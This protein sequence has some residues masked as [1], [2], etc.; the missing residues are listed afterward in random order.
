[1]KR[2]LHIALVGA[3]VCG[4]MPVS[5]GAFAAETQKPAAEIPVVVDGDSVQ[6]DPSSNAITAAGD[7]KISYKDVTASCDKASVNTVTKIGTLTGNTKIAFDGQE[8]T[9]SNIIF[10]FETKEAEMMGMDFEDDPFYMKAESFEA[11]GNE[12]FKLNNACISTCG[13]IGGKQHFLDYVIKAKHIEY[14]PHRKIVARNAWMTINDIP[15]MYS[16]YYAQPT[17]DRLPRV[18]LTPGHD[19]EKGMFLLAAWRYYGDEGFRGR[20]NTDYYQNKGTGL[21]VTHKYATDRVGDGLLKGY[22]IQDREKVSFEEK[23]PVKEDRYKVQLNHAYANEY[24]TSAQVQVNKFSDQYFMKDYFYREYERDVQPMSYGLM[25]QGFENSTIGVM[26]QKRVNDFYSQTEY[27]PKVTMD[28]YKTQLADSNFYLESQNQIASMNYKYAKPSSADYDVTRVDTQ[29]ILS[30]QQKIGA[31][32]VS[33]F[34]G[35]RGTYYSR[36]IANEK[37]IDRNAFIGGTDVSTKF[38]RLFDDPYQLFGNQI[39]KTLHVVTPTVRYQYTHAPTVATSQLYQFDSYDALARNETVSLILE[40][41]LSVKAKL[42]QKDPL[43]SKSG[44]RHNN[45]DKDEEAKQ[46][47]MKDP[48]GYTKWDALYLAPDVNWAL[49]EEGRGSHPTTAGYRME[50]RPVSNIGFYQRFSQDIDQVER[51]TDVTTDMNVTTKYFDFTV[52]HRY[53][54]M[55]ESQFQGETSWRFAKTW[56]FD[57]YY[58]YDD[59]LAKFEQQGIYLNKELNCWNSMLAFEMDQD[60]AQKFYIMFTLKAFPEAA[61]GMKPSYRGPRE[62]AAS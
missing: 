3:A 6:F 44:W 2:F 4:A 37:A 18:T 9:G 51:P 45:D 32:N 10:N 25:Q 49:D 55:E 40:N 8:V 58:R 21:G 11:K 12:E 42:A 14:Y 39:E 54:R 62:A 60:Y 50:L 53:L 27:L 30:Y 57:T 24:G 48:N 19:R 7:V 5:F 22:Y 15:F 61:V 31:I 17:K 20:I 41:K 59:R 13:P 35:Y 1:M 28:W 36:S 34:V 46:L 47:E 29:D 23:V 16:P 26:A 52:G 33:P 56:S 38:Y 43:I